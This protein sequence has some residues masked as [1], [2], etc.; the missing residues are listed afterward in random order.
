MHFTL[1]QRFK[2]F[3]NF[4]QDGYGFDKTKGTFNVPSKH[5]FLTFFLLFLTPAVVSFMIWHYASKD[6]NYLNADIDIRLRRFCLDQINFYTDAL[7]NRGLLTSGV[8]GFA[9][10]SV[11][12]QMFEMKFIKVNLSSTLW[13]R[14][15]ITKTVIRITISLIF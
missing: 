10:G 15:S 11:L 14:T 13:N 4:I 1:K 12:G 8:I 2:S 6:G 3:P 7:Y 9:G 5:F